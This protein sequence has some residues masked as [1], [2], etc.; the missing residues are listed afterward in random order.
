M[1]VTAL[2]MGFS[3]PERA[4]LLIPFSTLLRVGFHAMLR[5]GE[6]SRLTAG[7]VMHQKAQDSMSVVAI[8]SPKNKSYMGRQQFSVVRCAETSSWLR[9]LS[10]ELAPSNLLFSSR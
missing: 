5:P 9:W 2:A 3:D 7:D 1:A 4:R 10:E 6:P 8:R